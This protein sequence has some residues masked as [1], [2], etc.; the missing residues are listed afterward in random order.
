MKKTFVLISLFLIVAMGVYATENSV[1]LS[2]NIPESYVVDLDLGHSLLGF[3]GPFDYDN[4]D[5]TNLDLST[6]ATV[7][8]SI[9]NSNRIVLAADRAQFRLDV[10]ATDWIK[11][12]VG[13]GETPDPD[14][15]LPLYI[16][17][18][19]MYT[20]A[21]IDHMSNWAVTVNNNQP[22][23]TFQYLAGI[24]EA[25]LNLAHFKVFWNGSNELAAGDYSSTVT[26]TYTVT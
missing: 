21:N 10:S 25:D 8:F 22:Y 13:A 12:T 1:T 20:I 7:Y 19:V 4:N 2:A 26:I 14:E 3:E 17:Q 5:L 24:T 18:M 6:S 15:T 9:K 16:D 11:N 23:F